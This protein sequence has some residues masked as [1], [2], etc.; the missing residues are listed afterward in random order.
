MTRY[1]I[2]IARPNADVEELNITAYVNECAA[3]G[4]CDGDP[5]IVAQ[6]LWENYAEANPDADVDMQSIEE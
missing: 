5:E 1:I 4:E 2:R 3:C 6:C